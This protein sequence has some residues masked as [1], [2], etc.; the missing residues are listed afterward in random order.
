M[1][2]IVSSNRKL[3]TENFDKYGALVKLV[4]KLAIA[5]FKK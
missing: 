2:I 3:K 4:S 5:R 1:E